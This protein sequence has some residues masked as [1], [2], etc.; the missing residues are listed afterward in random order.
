MPEFFLINLL[1]GIVA[2]THQ[3]KKPSINLPEQLRL[4]LFAA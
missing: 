1:A 2:Y 4:L 3:L